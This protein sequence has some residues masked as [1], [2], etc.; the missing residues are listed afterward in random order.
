MWHIDFCPQ[1]CLRTNPETCCLMP[2]FAK[3]TA[4][5]VACAGEGFG[6][7]YQGSYAVAEGGEAVV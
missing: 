3:Q 6:V 1:R 7:Q 2:R 4:L 5:D